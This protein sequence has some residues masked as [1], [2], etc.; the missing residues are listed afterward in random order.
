[1][2]NGGGCIRT[3]IGIW[4][5]DGSFGEF[6]ES[7]GLAVSKNT[8][9]ETEGRLYKGCIRS[10]SGY[11]AESLSVGLKVPNKLIS[12]KKKMLRMMCGVIL[13]I[14]ISSSEVAE[15]MGVESI[16][17]WLRRQRLRWFAC[18]YVLRMY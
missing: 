10:V 2:N 3:I 11:G 18:G 15:R 16:E 13:W 7:G 8:G 12:T 6:H 5:S 4:Q 17:E 14:R 9:V 1:M